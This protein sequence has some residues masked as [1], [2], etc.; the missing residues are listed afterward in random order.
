MRTLWLIFVAM[1]MFTAGVVVFVRA[2][3]LNDH[4]L[5]GVAILGALAVVVANVTGK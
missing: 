5:A 1:V 4:L 2:S 3:S